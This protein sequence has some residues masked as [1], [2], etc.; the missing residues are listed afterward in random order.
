MT[1]TPSDLGTG[2]SA[3]LGTGGM[4]RLGGVPIVATQDFTGPSTVY[5][6]A[7]PMIWGA[8]GPIGRRKVW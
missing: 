7:T 3:T 6:T 8:T 2:P 5:L 1:R 4:T